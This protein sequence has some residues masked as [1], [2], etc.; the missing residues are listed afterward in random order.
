MKGVEHVGFGVDGFQGGE[1]EQRVE[2]VL[3]V[4]R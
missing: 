4:G 1:G 2:H 3:G